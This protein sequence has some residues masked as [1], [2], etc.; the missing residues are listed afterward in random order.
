[1]DTCQHIVLSSQHEWNTHIVKFPKSL[2]SAEEEIEYLRSIAH[3]S[4]LVATVLYDH[5]YED[6]NIKGYQRRLIA[7][8]KVTNAVKVK[9]SAIALDDAPTICTFV[10]KE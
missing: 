5:N 10:S 3:V 4:S 6:D 8:L 2:Q 9:I 1:M 7:S